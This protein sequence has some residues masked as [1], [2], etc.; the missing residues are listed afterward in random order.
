V[1]LWNPGCLLLRAGAGRGCVFLSST[2]CHGVCIRVTNSWSSSSAFTQGLSWRGSWAL[3]IPVSLFLSH[4]CHCLLCNLG[5]SQL[6]CDSVS[7]PVKWGKKRDSGLHLQE[8]KLSNGI[9]SQDCYCHSLVSTNVPFPNTFRSRS[10]LCKTQEKGLCG[11][12]QRRVIQQQ[13]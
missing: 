2:C 10:T 11:R 8:V 12:Q 1:S 5:K 3:G 7:S 9:S 13:V 4:L 6:L